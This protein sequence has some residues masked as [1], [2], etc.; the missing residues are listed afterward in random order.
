MIDFH[1]VTYEEAVVLITS[2]WLEKHIMAEEA[3]NLMV[4]AAKFFSRINLN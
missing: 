2:L 1:A 3:M 4:E